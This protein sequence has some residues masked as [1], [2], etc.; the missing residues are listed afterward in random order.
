MVTSLDITMEWRTPG[1]IHSARCGGTIHMPSSVETR[2][3]PAVA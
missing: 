1:G 3:V 2:I